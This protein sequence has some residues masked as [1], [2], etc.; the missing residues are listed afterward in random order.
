MRLASLLWTSTPP[1][2]PQLLP[3]LLLLL[4]LLLLLHM[5]R[6]VAHHCC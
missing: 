1:V 2:K 5:H 3:L 4:P 6:C